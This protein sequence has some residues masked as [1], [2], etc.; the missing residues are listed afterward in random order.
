MRKWHEGNSGLIIGDIW[1][2]S[3][4]NHGKLGRKERS[5]L[6]AFFSEMRTIEWIDNTQEVKLIDQRR[7]PGALEF[8][9]IRNAEEMVDA[10]KT[11]AVRGAPALGVAGAFGLALEAARFQPLRGETLQER[12]SS[13]AAILI[14]SRPTAVNLAYCINQV[15]EL[16]NDADETDEQTLAEKIIALALDLAEQDVNTNYQLAKNAA[17]LIADGDTIIHHCNTGSLAGVDWGTAL[18]GIRYAHEQGKRVHVLV[19]ETRPLLQGARLTAWEC[20]QYGI[21]FEIIT[22]NAA[23][24][25]LQSGKVQKV[26]F[27]ADRVAANGDVVNK[28][29]TYMLSL[30][31]AANKVP[32][33]C[34][35]PLATLDLS[36]EAGN[37]IIIEER[38]PQEVLSIKIGDRVAT[39]LHARALNPA[40]DLTPHGLITAWVTETGQI[41]PP[42]TQD[43]VQSRYN[44]EMGA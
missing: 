43:L 6:R 11:M 4:L 26:F 24:F 7:L 16:L 10:I 30:A 5:P 39:P 42:F 14:N 12:L 44:Q 33:V 40:F 9:T 20:Q 36:I 21:P 13:S 17:N 31:A 25:Y 3:G 1:S 15:L 29:G 19:D 18:G 41:K 28:V 23:G 37:Q 8:L 38:D 32:V 35:F 2:I 34:V 22:D 27:G